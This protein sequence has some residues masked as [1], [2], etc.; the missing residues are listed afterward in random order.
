MNSRE[1]IPDPD[2]ATH[3]L[4]ERARSGNRS[5]LE[6]LYL[7]TLPALVSWIELRCRSSAALRVDPG[8]LAQEVW[9]RVM[10]NLGRFDPARGSFRA[11]ILGFAKTVWLEQ[12]DPRRRTAA[13][14]RTSTAEALESVPDSVTSA[15]R[16]LA[17][18]ECVTRFLAYVEGLEHLDRMVVIHHGLEGLSCAA[19]GE[20]LELSADAVSK[21]WQRLQVRLRE[22]PIG[23]E[24][25]EP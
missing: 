2:Q 22:L 25:V 21:R 5:E 20:R 14:A 18:D 17:R 7:R 19:T 10:Q 24:L 6:A 12:L 9:L 11:W 23:L 1:G 3:A 4:A 13:R 15:T 8:D 16:A